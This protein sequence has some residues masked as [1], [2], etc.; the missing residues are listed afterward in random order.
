MAL[1]AQSLSDA[2]SKAQLIK[3]PTADEARR[4]SAAGQSA[5]DVAADVLATLDIPPTLWSSIGVGPTGS[6]RIVLDAKLFNDV[7]V[8][9]LTDV[10]GDRVSDIAFG[11]AIPTDMWADLSPF[12]GATRIGLWSTSSPPQGA[13]LVGCSAGIPWVN[14]AGTPVMVTAAHCRHLADG[15]V[16]TNVFTTNN[17]SPPTIADVMG[18]SASGGGATVTSLGPGTGGAIWSSILINGGYRGDLAEVKM[19][20]G[21]AVG[22]KFWSG[23]TTA[24]EIDGTASPAIGDVVCFSGATSVTPQCNHFVTEVNVWVNHESDSGVVEHSIRGLNIAALM[25]DPYGTAYH[26]PLP[27]DS[28]GIVWRSTSAGRKAAG[29]VSGRSDY[30]NGACA[31]IFTSV[32]HIAGGWAAPRCSTDWL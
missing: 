2:R 15:R 8:K 27:G 13:S 30:P 7:T 19:N 32:G 16:V 31:L 6:L 23:H 29:V 4:D 26:C 21:K 14:S 28:G 1:S 18:T 20:P 12:Y 22:G 11:R 24:Y 10:L 25:D 17:A 5:V 9:N 3:L